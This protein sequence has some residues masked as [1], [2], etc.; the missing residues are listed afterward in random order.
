MTKPVR[1][2]ATHDDFIPT[3]ATPGSAGADIYAAI[4]TTITLEAGTTSVIPCGIFLELPPL[5][6]AQIRPRS[7]LAAKHGITVL[8][9]PGTI[10]PDYRGEVC[11]ILHNTA[12][13]AFAIEPKM[14]IAQIVIAPVV[15]AEFK[16]TSHEELAATQR[17]EK[18]FG[19]S[20]AF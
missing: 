14:R 12:Q 3:Y 9:S 16:K 8:N 7:G 5:Y 17:G 6:E 19:S 4:D 18:G 15:Q 13:K 10:D 2:A 11:V 1:I 20:G